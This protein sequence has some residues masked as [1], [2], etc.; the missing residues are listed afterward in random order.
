MLI[1]NEF[2]VAAPIEQVWQH[3]L[4]VPRIVPCLPGAELTEVVGDGSY[5]GKVTTKL[6]P[7]SL[8]FSGTAEIVER[9]E[10]AKR[11]VMNAVGSEQKGKGRASM[12][13]TSTMASAG[14]GGTRVS[15]SQD[16]QL[17]GAAAQ[18]GRGM[19]SDV[20]TTLMRQFADCVQ[21]DIGAAARGEAP[22]ERAAAPV[23][24]LRLGMQAALGGLK[25]FFRRLFGG[26]GSR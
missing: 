20:T 8:R 3:M 6:G 16:L 15:V 11:V 12:S 14:N 7:V 25:R 9:D 21:A 19:V 26:G 18:Y 17:S 4:D 23:Q 5:E 2:E 22:T 24:G 13:L 1:E 10:T